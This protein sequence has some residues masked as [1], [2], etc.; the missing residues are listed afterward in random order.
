M[1]FIFENYILN[2]DYVEKMKT[3]LE[4]IKIYIFVPHGGLKKFWAIMAKADTIFV[5]YFID[6]ISFNFEFFLD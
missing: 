2:R 1:F 5:F 3:I 4:I 6:L